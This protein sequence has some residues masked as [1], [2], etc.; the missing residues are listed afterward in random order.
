MKRVVA[1]ITLIV[2]LVLACS[3]QPVGNKKQEIKDGYLL[4]GEYPQTVK[5]AD[6]TITDTVDHRGYYLG[7]DG[8]YYAKREVTP[9]GKSAVFSNK[10]VGFEGDVFYFKVEPI[11]WRVVSDYKDT[12]TLICDSILYGSVF[13]SSG[14]NNYAESDVRRS[15]NEDFYNV[16]FS[17][18]EQHGIRYFFQ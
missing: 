6:V 1:F 3:C 8:A 12:I 5:A 10:E 16:A 13:N 9:F 7:S 4:F 2:C 11:R 15:L 14:R 17:H 18:D